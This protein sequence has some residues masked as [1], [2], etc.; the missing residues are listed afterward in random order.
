MTYCLLNVCKS[1]NNQLYMAG[2]VGFRRDETLI[3]NTEHHLPY[4]SMGLEQNSFFKVSCVEKEK[5]N[6]EVIML[7]L[8]KEANCTI[9]N[10]CIIVAR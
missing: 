5:S 2:M 3:T 8:L 7:S 1:S 4:V 9:I 6:F 10:Y